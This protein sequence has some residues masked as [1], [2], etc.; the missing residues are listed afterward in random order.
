MKLQ[1]TDIFDFED[2]RKQVKYLV[3]KGKEKFAN[4][5]GINIPIIVNFNIPACCY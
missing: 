5:L 4:F 3:T 2:Y 1:Q